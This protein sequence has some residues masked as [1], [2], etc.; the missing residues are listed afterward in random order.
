MHWFIVSLVSNIL[1]RDPSIAVVV[2]G[3]WAPLAF[4]LLLVA[5]A[6]FL[7]K[8]RQ[9]RVHAERI[10]FANIVLRM[11]ISARVPHN[12]ESSNRSKKGATISCQ[13]H[14]HTDGA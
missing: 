5:L 9:G 12:A 13:R 2:A 11:S 6:Y 1:L 14:R 7:W 8:V 10:S 4:L 3:V